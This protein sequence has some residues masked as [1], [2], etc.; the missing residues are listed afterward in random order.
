MDRH[1]DLSVP[2]SAWKSTYTQNS[3]SG[4]PIWGNNKQHL[5]LSLE[6]VG[7]SD[8][9]LKISVEKPDSKGTQEA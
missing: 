4:N 2:F 6:P 3:S 8:I 5:D 9:I 1:S 7:D